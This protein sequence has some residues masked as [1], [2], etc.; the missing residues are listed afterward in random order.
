MDYLQS[1][2]LK[3]FLL[4]KEVVDMINKKEHLTVNGLAE[5]IHISY[6][7]NPVGSRN[8]IRKLELLDLIGYTNTNLNSFQRSKLIENLPLSTES[9]LDPNFIS[10]LI[11]G[12]G[13]FNITFRADGRIVP[14][15]TIT[16]DIH[17][18]DLLENIQKY[19]NCGSI[20]KFK[21]SAI[22]YHVSSFSD[23][24][25]NFVSFPHCK[26]YPLFTI[27][28]NDFKIFS[29]IC[30]LLQSKE[31]KN[32]LGLKSIIDLTYQMNKS[33]KYRKF[34]KDQILNKFNN[35]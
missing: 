23:L 15:F 6:H 11:D 4:F 29:D 2:K 10:G 19:F 30:S 13:S 34:T 7:M 35:S 22:R 24:I 1:S 26:S 16:Q 5:I 31:H 21:D 27:K 20:H 33:G 28:S 3:S 9:N 18:M 8:E 32:E 14:A 12:D 25:T 17:S